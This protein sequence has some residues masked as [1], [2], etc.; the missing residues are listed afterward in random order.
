MELSVN[1]LSFS[2]HCFPV[3][4]DITFNEHTGSLVCVLGKNGSG[5]TTLFRCILGSLDFHTGTITTDGEDIRKLNDQQRARKIAYIP[6]SHESAFSFPVI[7]MVLM[8]TT[9]SLHGLQLP[10]QKEQQTASD[11]LTMLG[12]Q[13]LAHRAFN[14]LSGGEQQL[15]LIARALAQHASILIMDEPCSSLD[16][17][18]QILV[19]QTLQKLR[20]MGYLILLSTHNPEHAILY[21]DEVIA[22]KNG[23]ILCRGK[24]AEELTAP[25][26]EQLY[27]VP[28]SIYTTENNIKIC[29]PYSGAEK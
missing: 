11:A 15:V 26:L 18:N 8:G 27:G 20:N 4:H 2:Y 28:V 23:S 6:Q 29:I 21:A 25:V 22:I 7:D 17:G 13:E 14:H 1:S 9:A 5:K 12:I 19:M 3:L 24:P 10:G 16:Y